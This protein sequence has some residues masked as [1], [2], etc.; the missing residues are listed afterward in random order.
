MFRYYINVHREIF[1]GYSRRSQQIQNYL[2]TYYTEM[3]EK[4]E[5]LVWEKSDCH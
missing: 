2:F 3:R 5:N 1:H 4:W